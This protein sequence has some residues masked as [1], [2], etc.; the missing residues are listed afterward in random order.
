MNFKELKVMARILD[1]IS[2]E[3]YERESYGNVSDE[4][5]DSEIGKDFN[6]NTKILKEIHNDIENVIDKSFIFLNINY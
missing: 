2:E 1:S 3:L 4:F 5:K 6:Q